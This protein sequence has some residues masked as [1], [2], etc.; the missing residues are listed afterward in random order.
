MDRTVRNRVT[1]A[2]T[3]HAKP[4]QKA[5]VPVHRISIDREPCRRSMPWHPKKWVWRV[6]CASEVCPRIARAPHSFAPL[7]DVGKW[8]LPVWFEVY[9]VR[10]HRTLEPLPLPSLL[11]RPPSSRTPTGRLRRPVRLSRSAAHSGVSI[12]NGHPAR[13]DSACPCSAPPHHVPMGATLPRR[14]LGSCWRNWPKRR[15]APG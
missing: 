6:E 8:S 15:G 10:T 13:A 7:R 12:C 5:S 2:D 11:E 1:R 14:G 4:A 3:R 9:L